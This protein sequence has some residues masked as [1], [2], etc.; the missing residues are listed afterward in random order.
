MLE[1]ERQKAA[2]DLACPETTVPESETRALFGLGIP[3]AADQS[4]SRYDWSFA[5][6]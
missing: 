3:L 4:Q 5:Y 1:C 6:P 2:N